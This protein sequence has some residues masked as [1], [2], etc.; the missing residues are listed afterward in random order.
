MIFI[1]DTH[2]GLNRAAHT[3]PASRERWKRRMV[4]TAMSASTSPV[5]AKGLVFHLGDL[6]DT[7][8]NQES[9]LLDGFVLADTCD[10][11]LAGNHDL[12]NR[13]SKLSSLELL[14][15]FAIRAGFIQNVPWECA[16][17]VCFVPHQRTQQD[18][19]DAL[20][21][22]SKTGR[23]VLATHC[24]YNSPF[25]TSDSTLNLSRELAEELLESFD[26]ILIGHEHNTRQDFDGRVTLL[27]SL[28]PTSFSDMEDKFYWE[29]EGDVLTPHLTWSKG[30]HRVLTWEELL[31]NAALPEL[32]F[33]TVTGRAPAKHLP[34]IAKA[35]YRL[36]KDFPELLA[37]RNKVEAESIQVEMKDV[38]GFRDIPS[39][40]SAEL[41]GTEME[42]IWNEYREKV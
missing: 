13:D 38:T 10:I 37:V 32:D 28:F 21:S 5:G 29:L 25:A 3:T 8:G 22:A 12:A 14:S 40:I 6:F 7:C 35:A 27:G 16:A 33:I 11:V 4:N 23:K 1:S 39:R 19:E 42:G 41:T 15:R 20:R 26:R 31:D 30:R 36:W 34:E 18:F 24:N 17:D 9:D 2:I